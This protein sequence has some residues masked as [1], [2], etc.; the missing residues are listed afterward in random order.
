VHHAIAFPCSADLLQAKE[1]EQLSRI[2]RG[3]Q[4]HLN[5]VRR[6]RLEEEIVEQPEEA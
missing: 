1:S 5:V 3:L 4:A 2:D 6:H